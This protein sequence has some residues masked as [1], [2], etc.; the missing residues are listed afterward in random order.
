MLQVQNLAAAR[1]GRVLFSGL[2]FALLAGQC[3]H[4]QGANGVG[5]TSL[6]KILAGLSSSS[7]SSPA[8]HM[9]WQG[10]SYAE[11]GDDF[12][13]QLHYLG[14]RDALK[15]TLS[16]LENLLIDARL[17]GVRLA[18]NTV[19]QVLQQVGLASYADLPVRQLS[20]GQKR[21]ATLARF[22]ALPRPIWVMDEPWVGLDLAGQAELGA[23]IADH[24]N[25]GG[26]AIL[27]SH[28]LLPEQIP[29]VSILTL[30]A[31]NAASSVPEA[32][33]AC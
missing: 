10:K 15:D 7:S 18:E 4:V 23:W 21:R 32:A 25:S 2:S 11:W 31:P 14:H 28:Q 27:T 30:Q 16:P 33:W 17:H 20:Q 6:L 5:K 24:L 26:I 12:G 9:S 13:A 19:L 22:L 8:G 29:G 1:G 3:L